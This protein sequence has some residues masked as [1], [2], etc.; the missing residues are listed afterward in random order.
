MRAA[1]TAMLLVVLGTAS[2]P[3]ASYEESVAQA[4]QGQTFDPAALR[5]A[6]AESASYDGYNT[7]I[8]NLR[9]PFL[10][11]YS[12][13]DCETA[14]RHGQ[15]ILEKNYVYIDGHYILSTCYRR[16]GQTDLADRH[17][18]VARGLVRAI[19]ASGD[20]KTPETAYVVIAVSE[21]Y[22]I[23]GVRG[24]KKVQQALINKDGHSYD[25]ITAET[26][27]GVKE[28]VYFNIDR[29]MRWSAERFGGKK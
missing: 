3:A 1:L 13:G 29:V 10:K 11:A 25:L 2:L 27:D 12:D 26:K 16:L 28:E 20:G 23:L 14:V 4:R 21:E 5:K 8:V 22:T 6:Y 15:A 9:A 18:A 7:D 24:L 19:L 17:I